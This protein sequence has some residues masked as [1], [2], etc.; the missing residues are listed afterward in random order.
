M[1][2][3]LDICI[4]GNLFV[5]LQA[6]QDKIEMNIKNIMYGCIAIFFITASCCLISITHFEKHKTTIH[7]GSGNMYIDRET[8]GDIADK[9]FENYEDIGTASKKIDDW[10]WDYKWDKDKQCF[11]KKEYKK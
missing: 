3:W 5:T 6:K 9:L 7:I 8:T 1:L 2:F 10:N 4:F 11:E